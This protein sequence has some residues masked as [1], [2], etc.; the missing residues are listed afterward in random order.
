MGCLHNPANVQQSS[1]NARANAG[2]LL[3]VY[4][5]FA[6]ICYNGAGRLLDRVNTLQV[7]QKLINICILLL[8]LWLI[9]ANRANAKLHYLFGLVLQ[10]KLITSM[11]FDRVSYV[12]CK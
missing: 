2:S 5:P 4:C 10:K 1:S 3:K 9:I 6:A 11:P 7:N 12:H 8:T